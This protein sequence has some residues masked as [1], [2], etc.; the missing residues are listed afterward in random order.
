[1][2]PRFFQWTVTLSRPGTTRDS[3]GAVQKTWESVSG[4]VDVPASV[5]PTTVRDLPLFAQRG[6]KYGHKVY[7]LQEPPFKR[8]DRLLTN[9]GRT[10]M[11]DGVQH[12]KMGE[13]FW[14]LVCD[15]I[16]E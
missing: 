4:F 6:L 15:Q 5:Q 2:S 3:A 7:V 9:D 12:F 10:F 13:E 16:V 14:L 11:I 1:M 8:G